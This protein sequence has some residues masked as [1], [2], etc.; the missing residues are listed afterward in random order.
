MHTNYEYCPNCKGIRKMN[1]SIA[2]IPLNGERQGLVMCL[3]CD[4]C[5]SYVGQI[6]YPETASGPLSTSIFEEKAGVGA[7]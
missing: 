4:S 5:S 1:V 6:P 2:M 7:T 3:H